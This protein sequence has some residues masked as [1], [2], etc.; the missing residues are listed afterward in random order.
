MIRLAKDRAGKYYLDGNGQKVSLNKLTGRDFFTEEELRSDIL[1]GLLIVCGYESA[2]VSELLEMTSR[3]TWTSQVVDRDELE[4]YIK[5]RNK[6]LEQNQF[7]NLLNELQY[8][9]RL[10]EGQSDLIRM[11]SAELVSLK[12]NFETPSYVDIDEVH[13]L[14][15]QYQVRSLRNIVCKNKHYDEQMKMWRS[16]LH[17]GE[18]HLEFRKPANT[19]R[20]LA[21]RVNYVPE[22]SKTYDSKFK[23]KIM[24]R[25]KHGVRYFWIG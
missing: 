5:Y 3:A 9:R 12:R 14:F 21:D 23:E 8:N 18:F 24:E 25:L 22:K 7:D 10:L 13:K 1:R 16:Y 4:K 2:E 19:K 6:Q 17:I 11:L 20:W 15:P